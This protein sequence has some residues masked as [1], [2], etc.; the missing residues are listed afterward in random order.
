[1]KRKLNR[2]IYPIKAP[3]PIQYQS[4]CGKTPRDFKTKTP[5]GSEE[6]GGTYN[7]NI[8]TYS[9]MDQNLF[10]NSLL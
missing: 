10:S 5:N 1:V 8:S 6:L 7:I 3:T 9:I 2:N 4:A